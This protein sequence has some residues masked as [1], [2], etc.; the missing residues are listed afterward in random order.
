MQDICK[1][2]VMYYKIHHD[3]GK[4]AFK[5]IWGKQAIYNT[6]QIFDKRK[7]DK[8]DIDPDLIQKMILDIKPRCHKANQDGL[9]SLITH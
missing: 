9:R 6:K 5:G 4:K 7:K 2:I 8:V 3:K 1:F